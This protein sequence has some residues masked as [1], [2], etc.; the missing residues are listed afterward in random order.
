MSVRLLSVASAACMLCVCGCDLRTPQERWSIFPTGEHYN[1]IQAVTPRYLWMQGGLWCGQVQQYDMQQR[2]LTAFTD[3]DGLPISGNGVERMAARNNKCLLLFERQPRLFLWTQGTGWRRLPDIEKSGEI[4]DAALDSDGDVVVLTTDRSGP[5]KAAASC[6]ILKLSGSTWRRIRSDSLPGAS[7]IV[8]LDE[9]Y[10]IKIHDGVGKLARVSKS[11]L[12]AP[13]ILPGTLPDENRLGYLQLGARTYLSLPGPLHSPNGRLG[14]LRGMQLLRELT[15]QGVVECRHQ[16]PLYLDLECGQFKPMVVT[17][18]SPDKA[19]CLTGSASRCELDSRQTPIAFPVR[20]INGDIWL[21]TQTYKDGKWT[22]VTAHEVQGIE[23]ARPDRAYYDDQQGRWRRTVPVWNQAFSVVDADKKLAWVM[24]DY[25]A[26]TMRLMDY[27]AAQ[28]RPVREVRRER[29]WGLPSFQDR[30]GRWWMWRW[31]VVRL[32]GDGNSKRYPLKNPSAIWLSPRTGEVW[33]A[34]HS[35]YLRHDPAQDAFVPA[36]LDL[37]YE[38][39]SF[40]IGPYEYS[41]VPLQHGLGMPSFMQKVQGRWE[42]LGQCAARGQRLLMHRKDGV[43]E[44]DAAAGRCVRLHSD[45]FNIAFDSKGRRILANH[46][47]ILLYDADPF[48]DPGYLLYAPLLRAQEQT[49]AACVKL[50]ASPDARI[51]EFAQEQIKAL[52]PLVKPTVEIMAEDP[53]LPELTRQQL[54]RAAAGMR[55]DPLPPSLFEAAHPPCPTY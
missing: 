4:Q 13:A 27:S 2:I 54:Q 34:D 14:D 44:Y 37:L 17:L 55:S 38:Q 51:R 1:F 32:D 25:S 20:D 8:P 50:L 40:K 5:A 43:W 7:A 39:F 52:S 16:T 49:L 23:A 31:N 30:Q 45:Y 29:D 46:H 26:A 18:L 53:R 10:I 28:P 6:S 15:S 3:R 48:D 33:A 47:T 42:P 41:S 12:D 9:C 22:P 36:T 11:A 35:R 21:P 19:T 24:D